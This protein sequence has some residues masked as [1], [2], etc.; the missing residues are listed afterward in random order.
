MK[1]K[2]TGEV[3]D[4]ATHR[5]GSPDDVSPYDANNNGATVTSDSSDTSTHPDSAEGRTAADAPVLNDA[6]VVKTDVDAKE[7]EQ[8]ASSWDVNSNEELEPSPD[9]QSPTAKPGS[10]NEGKKVRL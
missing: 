3:S 8:A 5:D 7:G 4:V 2:T 1:E 6:A 9:L 10:D